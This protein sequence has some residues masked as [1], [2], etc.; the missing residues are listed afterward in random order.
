[1]EC[2]TIR[3]KSDALEEKDWLNM[4]WLQALR[5]ILWKSL[6][7]LAAEGTSLT[8]WSKKWTF[9]NLKLVGL[10]FWRKPVFYSKGLGTCLDDPPTGNNF[11]YPALPAGAMYDAVYQCQ[12]QFGKQGTEVCTPLPEV[13]F[14]LIVNQF[15]DHLWYF[16][17][18]AW[19]DILQIC[20]RLW[21]VVDG[22]CTTMLKP[23]APGTNCGKHMVSISVNEFPL[24]FKL[25]Y[26]YLFICYYCS[27]A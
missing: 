11:T 3:K 12:L 6:G 17:Y 7:R 25:V 18:F 8:S 13:S 24:P 4:S 5:L 23:A 1:M 22:V 21:C 27:G 19:N 26:C 2:T 16:F 20:S 15:L 9:W 14:R 10:V